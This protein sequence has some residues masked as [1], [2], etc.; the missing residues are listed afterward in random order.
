MLGQ[1]VMVGPLD[2]DLL[3]DVE[4]DGS[5]LGRDDSSFEIDGTTVGY[6][7]G[8]FDKEG[9]EIGK[10]LGSSIVGGKIDGDSLVNAE[11]DGSEMSCEDGFF[12]TF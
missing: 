6:G 11:T 10:V 7:N 9:T 12:E 4:T 5:K 8:S 3:G 2:G 1:S